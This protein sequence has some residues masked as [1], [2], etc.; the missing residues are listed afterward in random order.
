MVL[1]LI[2]S[3]IGNDCA[4]AGDSPALTTSSVKE[5]NA[6]L[7]YADMAPIPNDVEEVQYLGDRVTG[8]YHLFYICFKKGE[9][10]KYLEKCKSLKGKEAI[11]FNP[12]KST[13]NGW[14]YD[15]ESVPKF[16][17]WSSLPKLG[18]AK[19]Y[20]VTVFKDDLQI[21]CDLITDL[22]S[23]VYILIGID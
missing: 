13:E 8:G 9:I 5:G 21:R 12:K 1:S 20:S 18:S 22:K 4:L 6:V 17:Y 7:V 23:V 15:E 19:V 3:I 2:F 14:Y 11:D 16:K 10:P